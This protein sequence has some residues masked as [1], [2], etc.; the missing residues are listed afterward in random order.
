[1]TR[2]EIITDLSE[3]ASVLHLAQVSVEKYY[4]GAAGAYLEDLES[5]ATRL[6]QAVEELRAVT[7]K[8]VPANFLHP[9]D[10]AFVP[11]TPHE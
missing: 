10:P 6:R 3:L 8:P 1:M 7:I 5:E 9:N 2:T 4:L 11:Y